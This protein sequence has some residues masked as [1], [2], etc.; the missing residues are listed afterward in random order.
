MMTKCGQMN[1]MKEMLLH[2]LL[3][4]KI[5]ESQKIFVTNKKNTMTFQSQIQNIFIISYNPTFEK[6]MF[7][8]YKKL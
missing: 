7:L 4:M 5:F 3:M 2:F 1:K 8:N 6:E